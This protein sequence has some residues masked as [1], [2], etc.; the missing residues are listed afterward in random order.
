MPATNTDPAV[1]W[2][3]QNGPSKLY[4]LLWNGTTWQ[5]DPL[6][7][8][9]AGK[10]IHYTTGLGDPDS[11][12]LRHV[13]R[14]VSIPEKIRDKVRARGEWGSMMMIYYTSPPSCAL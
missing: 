10:T 5:S 4:R 6:N 11:R 3:I 13:E 9:S 7:S 1:L 2:A 8:W 12:H 14:D